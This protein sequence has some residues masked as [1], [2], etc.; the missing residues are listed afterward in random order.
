MQSM[1]IALAIG[2]SLFLAT[3][4]PGAEPMRATAADMRV[5]EPYLGEF[6][7]ATQLFDDGKTEHHFLVKYEWFDRGQSIVKFTISMV[8]PSQDRVL[9]NAEGFY[10]FDSIRRQLY[11]FGAFSHG[12]SGW[13]TICEFDLDTG[14]RTICAQ[15]MN[16]DG[17]VTHVRDAF[18]MVDASSWKNTT[19]IRHQEEGDWQLAHEG[20]YT[21]IGP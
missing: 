12:A 18:E 6:R 1:A 11:V 14:A 21:R 3:S 16:P 13:G 9:R 19:R 5:M 15:T 8:I 17:T 7:S 2:G 10:G 4:P 20:I